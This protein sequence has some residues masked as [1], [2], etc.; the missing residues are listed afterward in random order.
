MYTR[1]LGHLLEYVLREAMRPIL[2][3]ECISESAGADVSRVYRSL[4]GI[5]Y[6]P[7]ANECDVEL[8]LCTQLCGLYVYI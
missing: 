6:L 7:V 4:Q 3:A 8:Y 2:L 1:L 5:R